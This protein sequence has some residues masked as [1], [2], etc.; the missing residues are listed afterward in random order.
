MVATAW[1]IWGCCDIGWRDQARVGC[2]IPG[3][4]MISERLAGPPTGPSPA[5]GK[6][7]WSSAPP[8]A[9]RWAHLSNGT[10]GSA[11]CWTCHTAAAESARAAGNVPHLP[12]ARAAENAR[13]ALPAATLYAHLR[14][15][16]TWVQGGWK[17]P[18]QALSELLLQRPPHPSS[19]IFLPCRAGSIPHSEPIAIRTP[20]R[21]LL[22]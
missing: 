7:T 16:P 4:I 21:R 3:M 8:T 11:C 5:T 19:L 2:G 15:S 9:A 17:T 13:A 18:A 20:G 14:R 1:M 12:H 10:P 22:R 6:A